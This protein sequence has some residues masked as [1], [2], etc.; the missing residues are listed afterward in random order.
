MIAPGG[1]EAYRELHDAINEYSSSELTP[2]RERAIRSVIQN[3]SWFF[4]AVELVDHEVYDVNSVTVPVH[5]PEGDV[6]MV[7]RLA[8]LPRG[9]KG[10]TVK[11]W[12]RELKKAAMNIENELRGSDGAQYLHDYRAWYRSDSPM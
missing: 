4:A 12:I 2:A 7:V 3:M 8:Q 11:Q 5:N 9:V 1:E 6:S 10:N